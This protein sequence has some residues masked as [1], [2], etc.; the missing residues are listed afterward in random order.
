MG[1]FAKNRIKFGG[2]Y[3]PAG[4]AVPDELGIS[5]PGL[6]T[7]TP[8]VAPASPAVDTDQCTYIKGDGFQCKKDAAAGDTYCKPHRKMV[9]E[10]RTL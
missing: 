5:Y 10:G 9:D 6:V 2:K 3:Y 8:K 7:G 1:F 4:K